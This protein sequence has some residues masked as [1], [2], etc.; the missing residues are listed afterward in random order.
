[1]SALAYDTANTP[2][3]KNISY[4][5]GIS[6]SNS[7][8]TLGKTDGNITNFHAQNVGTGDIWIIAQQGNTQIRKSINLQVEAT[9]KS[10]PPNV[11]RS[12]KINITTIN[13]DINNDGDINCKDTEILISQYGQKGQSLPADLNYDKIVNQIDYN[14]LLRNYTPGNTVTC[15]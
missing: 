1:M 12:P 4:T 3:Y 9:A 7:I 2:I 15:P 5:W 10:N 13:A 11:S 8:G 6:S 14:T